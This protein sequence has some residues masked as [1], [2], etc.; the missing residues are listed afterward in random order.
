MPQTRPA[1]ISKI[2]RVGQILSESEYF[3]LSRKFG[4]LFKASSGA[5]AVREILE[6]MDLKKEV[7]IMEADIEEMKDP[8]TQSKL[9]RRLK[10]FKAMIKNGTRP[11]WMVMTVLPV[12]PPDLRPMVAL[13]GG[14]FATSDSER[15]L[16]P[17][18]QPQ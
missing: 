1:I 7:K 14:R 10:M 13:D 8:M 3:T 6:G 18:H 17:R 4:S 9:L 5:E 16:S 15:P 11:E 2:L 12:L